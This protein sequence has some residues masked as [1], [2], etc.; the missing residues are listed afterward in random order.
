MSTIMVGE[1]LVGDG[2]GI[3]GDSIRHG[4]LLGTVYVIAKPTSLGDARM[5]PG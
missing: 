2:K 4:E 5:K 1:S 3:T